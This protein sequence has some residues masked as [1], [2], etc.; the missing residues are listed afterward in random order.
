MA[1]AEHVA[2]VKDGYRSWNDRRRLVSFS[3]DLSG[4][5][6]KEV[7]PGRDNGK[8]GRGPEFR[9]FDFTGAD[10]HGAD[11]SGLDFSKSKFDGADLSGAN[12][13]QG[14]FVAAT[15]RGANLSNVRAGGA[16]LFQVDLE[17]AVLVGSDLE[18]RPSD[19]NKADQRALPHWEL[20]EDKWT[21]D[22]LRDLKRASDP[23]DIAGAMRVKEPTYQVLFATNRK[24]VGNGSGLSFSAERSKNLSYGSCQV[25][26]PRSHEVGS[27]GSSFFKRLFVGDDRLK[28]RKVIP[29]N[30]ELHWQIVNENF[31]T[32]SGSS[33]P[34]ILI[35]GYNSSFLSSVLW[36]AQIGFDLGLKRGISLFSWPSQG[37]TKDYAADEA[38]TEASKYMLM[39]YL[40][41]YFE[42]TGGVPINIIAHSMGCRCLVGAL[43]LIGTKTPELLGRINHIIM[44]AADVDQGV[45]QHAGLHIVLNSGR[46]TSYVCGADV[47]LAASGWLHK[48]ARV[49]LLPPVFLFNEID[50][51]EVQ[52]TDLLNLGHGY[53]AETKS[54][55]ADMFQILIHSAAPDKRFS[56]R[57]SD[58]GPNA[59]WKLNE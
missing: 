31:G 7:L 59:H 14:I 20:P 12:L 19:R 30:G 45:M 50:T 1:K 21:T 22:N 34:T 24:Q 46:T 44:A 51:V 11:L 28:I 56:I 8:K 58:P 32:E 13:T 48:Y 35:H 57:R 9:R 29:L 37:Q 18:D 10:L 26:V 27:V 49:G 41:Q 54:I 52:K 55:L 6:F 15:F 25:F 53:V 16:V 47:A 5:D 42:N 36:A 40:L 2:W 43:E 39:E 38:A 3:P 33:P 4:L 17:G 23:S